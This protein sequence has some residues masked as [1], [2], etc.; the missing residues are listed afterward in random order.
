[1]MCVVFRGVPKWD[2]CEFRGWGWGWGWAGTCAGA[3]VGLSGG[4]LV[5]RWSKSRYTTKSLV[6]PYLIH[7]LSK[8]SGMS[9]HIAHDT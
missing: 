1:M 5:R 2:K 7:N 6:K 3:D 9:S 4:M 8:V